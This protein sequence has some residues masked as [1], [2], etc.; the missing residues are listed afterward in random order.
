MRKIF[1]NIAALSLIVTMV[2]CDK[3]FD[4]I[5]TSPNDAKEAPT[6]GFFNNGTK[7][8]MDATRGGFSSGRMV[9]PWVQ[10][11]AQRN[12]TP[13]DRYQFRRDVN[14][15]L[16]GNIYLSA[17]NYKK[18]IELATDPETAPRMKAFGDLDNQIASARIMLSYCFLQLVDMYGDVPYYSYGNQDPD[19]QALDL[20]SNVLTPKF[21]SQEKI[22]EDLM[23]ELKESAEMIKLEEGFV[24]TA[25]DHVFGTPE[26]MKKFANSLR[27]RIANRL[28]GVLPSAEGHI[29]D[30][31]ASGVM[32]SNEDGVALA[33]QNDHVFPS[34]WYTAF[35]IDNRNDFAVTNTLIDLLKGKL[36]TFGV[37]PRL[38]QYAAPVG[39]S[40][41]SI[42][43]NT[44]ESSDDISKYAGM[45]YG[46]PDEMTSSQRPG[47]SSFSSNVLRPNYGEVFMEYSEV[48]FLLSENNGWDDTH[49]KNGV[50]ASME[51]W[52][53]ESSKIDAYIATLDSASE[54]NVIT[55]KYIA[56]YM[57][58]IEA[59]SEYRR[60]GFPKTL[61][62][63]GQEYDLT[64]PM[65]DGTT[66]YT[67]VPLENLTDLPARI[68]YPVTLSTLNPANYQQ[69]AQNI[70][71]DKMDTKLIWDKN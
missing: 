25:G 39:T 10:Y 1:Y 11:S 64:V 62:L 38:Q 31:I 29:Q 68:L 46:I 32:E 52:G 55:Q 58:P 57:Q 36:G 61:L 2:S 49:Y 3:D 41:A 35:F 28:K 22:Y 70:G 45:P 40:M 54:E 59:W 34:P 5:N 71:G 9:L 20:K 53:V 44:Y 66:K 7:R 12:Y 6:Y 43:D 56:L 17:E 13:E 8:I 67:F 4:E 48:E 27:L 50:R 33:Y 69:A 51:R 30:A 63:P 23:K 26:K 42:R 21:A 14:S 15:S 18:I 60:T 19:F 24:Y 47:A 65:D 37:D 16:Y